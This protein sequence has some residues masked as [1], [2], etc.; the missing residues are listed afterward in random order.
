MA[1]QAAGFVVGGEPLGVDL[2]DTLVTVTDPPTDLLTDADAVATWWRLEAG[3]LP[4]S[5]AAPSPEATRRLRAAL[6][7]LLDARLASDQLA[8]D[9]V[10]EVNAAA[11]AAPTSPEL[12][13]DGG[14]GTC[15]HSPDPGDVAL[16]AAASSV[17]ELLGSPEA[18][19]L[20][21]CANPAC[22]MLFV[23]TDPRR[24]YC[25]QNVCANRVRVA[26]H[27]RRHRGDPPESH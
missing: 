19:R 23:A 2:A 27:Y 18:D 15:W 8:A 20:R 6:R 5:A 1:F 12:S 13:P 16:A 22:S 4:P 24:R 17:I 7:V 3:R 14:L 9:A 25:T 21:R 26:R 10:A 11:A